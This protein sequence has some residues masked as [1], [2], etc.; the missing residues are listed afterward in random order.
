MDFRLEKPP[1]FRSEKEAQSYC[2][3]RSEASRRGKNQNNRRVI[4]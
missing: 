4:E 2:R 3:E 1:D